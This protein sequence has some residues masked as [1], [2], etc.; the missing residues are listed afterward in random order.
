MNKSKKRVKINWLRENGPHKVR[1]E[2]EGNQKEKVDIQNKVI[3]SQ[4]HTQK[5]IT[6]CKYEEQRDRGCSK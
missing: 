3:N 4:M 5:N 6:E 1:K 2:G